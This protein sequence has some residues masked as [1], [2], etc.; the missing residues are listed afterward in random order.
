MRLRVLSAADVRRAL[1]MPAAIEAMRGAFLALHR[2]DV[3]LPVRL[4]MT[5]PDGVV[6]FMP[7]YDGAGGLG[8]KVVTVFG[9]NPARGL[10][11][12][13]A[14][15]TLYDAETG[16]PRAL[17]EGTTL[18]ALRT[19][20]VAGLAT[21]LLARPDATV[22][23]VFGAGAAAPAQI[24]AV[25][26]VRSIEQVYLLSQSDSAKRLAAQ[27]Q[28][29]D[30]TR[31]YTA[32]SNRDEAVRTA[33]VITTVTT[34]T[35]PTFDSAVVQ[36]NTHINGMGSYRPDMQEVDSH[37][38][39]RASVCV[40]Q[41]A[42]ILEEAGDLIIPSQQGGWSADRIYAELA[43]LVSGTIPAPADPS[44]LTFFKSCGLAIEDIAAAQAVLATAEREG[45]GQLI[46]L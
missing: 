16:L 1:P 13:N 20:A 39:Q 42:S 34:S 45:L 24:E 15:V 6:L 32:T 36:P 37:L 3:Q 30:P 21:D 46:D 9:G 28:A 8:Q 23:T 43:D 2:G 18:T 11:T 22:L 38:I 10:P 25:C 35:T 4:R 5:T 26:A 17:L 31:R 14:L 33:H 7:A 27:L 44:R 19:G 41:R 40:E 29:S 12:V